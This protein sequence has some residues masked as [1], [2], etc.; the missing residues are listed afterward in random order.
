MA[1]W[2]PLLVLLLAS[3]GSCSA[4]SNNSLAQ[5]KAYKLHWQQDFN[6]LEQTKISSWLEQSATSSLA[7]LGPY[8]FTMQLYIYRRPANEPVPWANTWRDSSQQIHFYVEPAFSLQ[9]FTQDW[10]AYHEIAHLALPFLGRSNAW[11]AE[12]FASFMQYHIMQQAGLIENAGLAISAKFAPQREHYQQ[13]TSM[14]ATAALLL[15]QR[16]FP[17][18]YWGGAQFF[19]VADRQL[20]QQGKGSLTS[21]I[22]SYQHCCRLQDDTLAEVIVSLDTLSGSKIFSELMQQFD[23]LPAEQFMSRH[24]L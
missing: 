1:K 13:Q 12:G 16:R 15:G 2:L 21:L 22:S 3:S 14:A 17:A 6:P 7:V 10:T 9:Q 11:F 5:E 8:P 24:Q 19:V 4:D 23:Q 20:Q 18:G